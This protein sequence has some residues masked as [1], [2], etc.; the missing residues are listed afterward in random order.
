[1]GT[2]NMVKG[3]GRVFLAVFEPLARVALIYHV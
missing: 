3:G 1:M 2:G